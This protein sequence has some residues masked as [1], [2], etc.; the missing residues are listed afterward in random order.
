VPHLNKSLAR[1]NKNPFYQKLFDV[2]IGSYDGAEICELFG[3]YILNLL[4][5]KELQNNI[6]LYRDDGLAI[7]RDQPRQVENTKKVICKIFKSIGLG[8]ITIETNKKI[9]NFLDITLNLVDATHKPFNKPGNTP[10][11]IHHNS[12]HP[13]PHLSLETSLN[14]STKDYP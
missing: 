14:P 10:I 12:N 11:Y 9:I 2:P 7:L 4:P 3:L 8:I 1:S 5:M 13:P 6:R